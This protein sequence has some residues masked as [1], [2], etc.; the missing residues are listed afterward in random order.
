MERNIKV[1]LLS[2]IQSFIF[3]PPDDYDDDQIHDYYQDLVLSFLLP[4]VIVLWTYITVKSLMNR[5][6]RNIHNFIMSWC[7]VLSVVTRFGCIIYS[8]TIDHNKVVKVDS[9]KFYVY[10]QLPFDLLN[11]SVE[12]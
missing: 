6:N 8:I 10:Y 5:D 7:L 1:K 12:A 2:A 3:T 9:V 11:I 4:I